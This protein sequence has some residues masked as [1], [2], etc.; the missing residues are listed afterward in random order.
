MSRAS[1][2]MPFDCSVEEL[3][4]IIEEVMRLYKTRIASEY[5]RAA[6]LKALGRDH[7]SFH[8]FNA[9]VFKMSQDIKYATKSK[10]H[11]VLWKTAK[12]FVS[13]KRL[14]GWIITGK[15]FHKIPQG[16][17]WASYTDV[18]G[19]NTFHDEVAKAFLEVSEGNKFEL[20][21]VDAAHFSENTEPEGNLIPVLTWLK[22]ELAPKTG[23]YK[24]A[25]VQNIM[26]SAA[27]AKTIES[28]PV[29]QLCAAAGAGGASWA[30]MV[31]K[32]PMKAP[33]ESKKEPSEMELMIATTLL[34]AAAGERALTREKID[35]YAAKLALLAQELIEA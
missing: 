5:V 16:Q 1:V 12:P 30:D 22:P 7:E 15:D 19:A 24:T 18:L 4:K 34:A 23:P 17:R 21:F 29:E 25:A 35:E 26:A 32:L 2:K 11:E 13:A 6:L 27:R 28:E 8:V 20:A 33:V 14:L 3:L 10:T 31:E 9:G